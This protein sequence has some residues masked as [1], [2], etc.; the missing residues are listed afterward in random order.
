MPSALLTTLSAQPLNSLVL[1]TL[2]AI[3]ILQWAKRWDNS[4]VSVSYRTAILERQFYRLL[5][6]SFAHVSLL[7]L[8]FNAASLVSIGKIEEAR[9]SAYYANTTLQLLLVCPAMFMG[10][11]YGLLK[12]GPASMAPRLTDAAAVGYSGVLFGWMTVVAQAD[13]TFRLSL[14][15][16]LSLPVSLAP[17]LS[18]AFTQIIVPQASFLGHLSGIFAGFLLYAGGEW[19]VGYWLWSTAVLVV[20]AALISIKANPG[21]TCC[22]PACVTLSPAFVSATGLGGDVVGATAAAVRGSRFVEG[23]VLR[24]GGGAVDVEAGGA[25]AGGGARAHPLMAWL[26]RRWAGTPREA[27]QPPPPVSE[28]G[29]RIEMC[30]LFCSL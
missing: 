20:A 5:S 21:C 9:G 23:G 4:L 30:W 28:E 26:P 19:L 2:V 14:P 25:P 16:G 12:H 15:G 18:L 22:T 10:L 7:H 1:A 24:V 8:A 27:G 29:A 6:A 13:P 17:F 3:F 11:T